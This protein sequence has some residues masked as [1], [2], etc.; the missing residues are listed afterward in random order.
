MRTL[1]PDEARTFYDRFGTKQ[2]RQAF[3]EAAALEALVANS[4]F[5]T[6]RSVLEFGCGTGRFAREIL[7]RRLPPTARY[8]GVD[9]SSTMVRLASERLSPFADRASVLPASGDPVLPATDGS[10][11][12]FVSTYVLDLLPEAGVRRVLGEARRVLRPGGLLCLAGI[13]PGTTPLS[14]FVMGTWRRIF[15]V[16][17]AWVGGC[18]PTRLTEY[19]LPEQWDIRFRS[20]VVAWGV[21]SEVL[22]AAPR[23]P[24]AGSLQVSFPGG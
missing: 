22:V 13:A 23:G 17:P 11:D 3:Y 19:V 12:R 10:I 4:D 6:A 5:G 1:T 21:A 8:L 14:R 16:N 15:D 18:R 2:D 9:L 20:V 7:E 24:M